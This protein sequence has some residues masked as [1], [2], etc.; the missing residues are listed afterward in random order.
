H[1]S[2]FILGINIYFVFLTYWLLVYEG[3]FPIWRVKIHVNY[4][5]RW[6]N[7]AR[8]FRSFRHHG[9]HVFY[10]GTDCE[11]I[12]FSRPGVFCA[13]TRPYF[14]RCLYEISAV[15]VLYLA[16]GCDGSTYT[17]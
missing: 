15:S 5:V 6:I 12:E 3:S 14:T 8:W 16:A 7:D 17:G 11:C 9:R 10:P 4:S 13:G 1:H 2:L